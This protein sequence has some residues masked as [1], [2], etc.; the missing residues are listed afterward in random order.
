[1]QQNPYQADTDRFLRHRYPPAFPPA[2]SPRLSSAVDTRYFHDGNTHMLFY[3]W[4]IDGREFWFFPTVFTQATVR[5]YFWNGGVWAT[6][7]V[8]QEMIRAFF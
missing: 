3:L 6:V 7:C 2:M 4:L 8:R 1:M 5:G